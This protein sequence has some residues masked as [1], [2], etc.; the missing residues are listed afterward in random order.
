MA[1][2]T[3]APATMPT[4]IPKA[5]KVKFL[6]PHRWEGIEDES[7]SGTLIK[8]RRLCQ[9]VHDAILEATGNKFRVGIFDDNDVNFHIEIGWEILTPN[10]WTEWEAWNNHTAARHGLV[11]QDGGLLM[12]NHGWVCVIPE[13]KVAKWY[14]AKRLRDEERT[15]MALGSSFA[16]VPAA[17]RAEGKLQLTSSRPSKT[18]QVDVEVAK[19]V[20]EQE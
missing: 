16:A 12:P 5:D 2:K 9:Y 7:A 17:G 20:A 11:L 18:G 3:T 13:E 1:D 14:K 6:D 19:M 15:K 10:H 4:A 8:T